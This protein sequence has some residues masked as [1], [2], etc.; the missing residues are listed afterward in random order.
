MNLSA[1]VIMS[2]VQE[3]FSD[4]SRTFQ[5]ERPDVRAEFV[6]IAGLLHHRP[7]RTVGLAPATDDIGIPAI[8]LQLGLALV[9]LTGRTTA[10][11]DAQGTWEAPDGPAPATSDGSI[12]AT[13]WLTDRLALMTPRAFSTSG[14]LLDLRSFFRETSSIGYVIVDMTGFEHTG[15]HLELMAL[16]DVVAVV[17]RAG[18]TTSREVRRWMLEIPAARN[19]GVLLAGV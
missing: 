10:V 2:R 13:T 8:A 5:S 14:V 15:E 19:L 6:R 18:L 17:A 7:C 12:F 9:E 1:Q 4:V 11:I 3:L 16:L